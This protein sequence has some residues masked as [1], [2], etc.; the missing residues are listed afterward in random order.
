MSTQ[1][2]GITR[3]GARYSQLAL[4]RQVAPDYLLTPAQADERIDRVEVTI[5]R[6][7]DDVCDE[8]R[9]TATERSTLWG[10]EFLNPYI[11]YEHP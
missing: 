3:D 5:R 7:W 8:A 2:V 1:A 11:F 10:R 4:C 9:L 6:E